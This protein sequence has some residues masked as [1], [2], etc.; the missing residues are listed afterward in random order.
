[1]GYPFHLLFKSKLAALSNPVDQDANGRFPYCTPT[2][3]EWIL[4]S[5]LAKRRSHLCTLSC[6]IINQLYYQFIYISFFL[7]KRNGELTGHLPSSPLFPL[8][9]AACRLPFISFFRSFHTA[10]KISKACPCGAT[11]DGNTTI[12][13]KPSTS[14]TGRCCPLN[15]FISDLRNIISVLLI[16][17]VLVYISVSQWI[18]YYELCN[19]LMI[20]YKFTL[21]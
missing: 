15:N 16:I 11:Y 9:F 20:Y 8:H 4:S 6:S 21:N 18:I 1:M 19:Y 12:Q 7:S 17:W 3:D 2:S 13:A 14:F 5:W 10:S